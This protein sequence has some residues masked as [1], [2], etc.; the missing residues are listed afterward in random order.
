MHILHALTPCQG[1]VAALKKKTHRDT[2]EIQTELE[3]TRQ[4]VLQKE[5]GTIPSITPYTITI[6]RLV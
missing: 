4:W 2:K 6:S 3:R 5:N 1:S